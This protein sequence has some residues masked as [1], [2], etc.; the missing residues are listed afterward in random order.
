MPQMQIIALL[1]GS[2]RWMASLVEFG[3]GKAGCY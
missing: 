3:A 2:W 1:E